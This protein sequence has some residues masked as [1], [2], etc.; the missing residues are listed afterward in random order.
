MFVPIRAGLVIGA[1]QIRVDDGGVQSVVPKSNHVPLPQLGYRL[2]SI[3]DF[4]AR[5][6]GLSN[7]NIS[8]FYFQLFNFPFM[9]SNTLMAAGNF[10]ISRP[11]GTDAFP[12]PIS[13]MNSIPTLYE[14]GFY[15]D[16]PTPPDAL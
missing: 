16:F 5:S 3:A 14:K 11:P 8:P 10:I 1:G 15:Q 2:L 4:S 7:L 12:F 13:L 9:C 6:D